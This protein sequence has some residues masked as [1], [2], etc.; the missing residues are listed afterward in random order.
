M[1]LLTI[2]LK[3]VLDPISVMASTF[4]SWLIAI[5]HEWYI[6]IAYAISSIITYLYLFYSPFLISFEHRQLLFYYT[7]FDRERA[8]IKLQVGYLLNLISQVLD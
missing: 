1:I 8:M 5:C 6:K 3:N 2:S 7:A 4:P